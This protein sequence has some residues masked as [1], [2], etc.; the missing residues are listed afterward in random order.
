MYVGR[1]T[2]L[3]DNVLPKNSSKIEIELSFLTEPLFFDILCFSME[4]L[5]IAS[6]SQSSVPF[7]ILEANS[8]EELMPPD[9]R[10]YF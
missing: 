10:V 5:S 9:G 4:Y 6:T 7:K 2:P 3:F 1:L 8:V